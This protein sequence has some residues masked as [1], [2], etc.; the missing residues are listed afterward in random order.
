MFH[1]RVVIINDIY[2]LCY[3]YFNISNVFDIVTVKYHKV[4]K[5]NNSLRSIQYTVHACGNR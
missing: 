1:M 5:C 3:T 2:V 4:L